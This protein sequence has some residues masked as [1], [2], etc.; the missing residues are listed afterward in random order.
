MIDQFGVGLHNRVEEL[1]VRYMMEKETAAQLFLTSHSTNLLSNS[2]LR[3]DQIFAVERAGEQEIGP[4][5]F[6]DEQPRV[7]QNLEKMYL[8]GVFGGLPSYKI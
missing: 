5:R 8:S 6:S 2:L 4:H 1:L 3:P 7:A